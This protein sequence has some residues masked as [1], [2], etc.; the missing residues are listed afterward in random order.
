MIRR[1]CIIG[2]LSACCWHW[3]TCLQ[4][5]ASPVTSTF[6]LSL[7]HLSV[8]SLASQSACRLSVCLAHKHHLIPQMFGISDSTQSVGRTWQLTKL[9]HGT[10]FINQLRN[11][12]WWFWW[13]ALQSCS[14]SNN[15][16]ACLAM[17][18]LFHYTSPDPHL[19]LLQYLLM[20]NWGVH[21]QVCQDSLRTWK[22]WTHTPST[23]WSPK[24]SHCWS[25]L[26]ITLHSHAVN[27][28]VR[29]CRHISPKNITIEKDKHAF[30]HTI[31]FNSS[32]NVKEMYGWAVHTDQ[33]SQHN[34][35]K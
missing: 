33:N 12:L 29:T 22:Q 8:S 30:Q 16:D 7:P 32:R 24:N 10:G 26:G 18:N 6:I 15:W 21:Q 3:S 20:L 14:T 4:E 2:V 1:V 23:Q 11:Q 5:C 28:A 19:R 31:N 13:N 17:G 27:L 9:R 35:V 34:N 25:S